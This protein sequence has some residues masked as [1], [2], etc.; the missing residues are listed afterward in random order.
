VCVHLHL[1]A[2]VSVDSVWQ[3]VCVAECICVFLYMRMC[4]CE[5]L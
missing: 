2:C 4:A 1:H 3:G 5:V